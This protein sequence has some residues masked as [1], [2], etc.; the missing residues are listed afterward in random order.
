MEKRQKVLKRKIDEIYSLHLKRFIDNLLR[1]ENLLQLYYD[2][3]KG[4]RGRKNIYQTDILRAVVVFLHATLEDFL[5][6]VASVYLPQAK[7]EFLNDIPL[8]GINDTG[9]PEKFLLGKLSSFQN[10]TVQEVI[11]ES[12]Q[13]YLNKLSFSSTKDIAYLLSSLS[14]RTDHLK[15]YFS[16]LEQLIQRRHKIVHSADIKARNSKGQNKIYPID[17]TQVKKWTKMLTSFAT[18]L[19]AELINSKT[20]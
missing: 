20:I 6:S 18:S 14:I 10:K 7:E 19:T 12:A 4:R 13:A 3:N 1:A 17:Y 15:S 2:K 16:E 8:I 5:R 9:R 11:S